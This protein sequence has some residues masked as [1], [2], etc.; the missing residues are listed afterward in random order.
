MVSGKPLMDSAVVRP[1]TAGESAIPV[2]SPLQAYWASLKAYLQP[3]ISGRSSDAVMI[4]GF[5][6]VGKTALAT[7]L[8]RWASQQLPDYESLFIDCAAASVVPDVEDKRARTILEPWLRYINRLEEE[9][10][11]GRVLVVDGLDGLSMSSGEG[12]TVTRIRSGLDRAM[13]AQG[14]SPSIVISTS[15]DPSGVDR[16]LLDWFG[17]CSYVSAPGMQEM[18]NWFV[19]A[20][21]TQATA[22]AVSGEVRG[23]V[24]GMD[25]EYIAPEQLFEP[26][27]K[28]ITYLQDATVDPHMFAHRICAGAADMFIDKR[29]NDEYVRRNDHFIKRSAFL[30]RAVEER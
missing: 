11:H 27:G 25:I 20:G 9:P 6:G 17:K 14:A 26:K 24:S 4:F 2:K 18:D 13:N 23:M 30:E 22:A 16:N 3:A 15:A 28:F 19:A 1:L 29:A 12:S 7:E 8:G 5:R 21:M 10:E